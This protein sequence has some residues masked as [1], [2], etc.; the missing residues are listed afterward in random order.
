MLLGLKL[1]FF[2]TRRGPVC[3]AQAV[4]RPETATK[5]GRPRAVTIEPRVRSGGPFREEI[6]M[7]GLRA[8]T[9]S[10]AACVA[11]SALAAPA[12]AE[13]SVVTG[14]PEVAEV[15]VGTDLGTDDLYVDVFTYALFF[16]G[17]GL[18]VIGDSY[19][20]DLGVDLLDLF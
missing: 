5:R 9:V 17:V 6:S 4:F 12:S 2:F 15:G 11:F 14:V 8:L 16:G 20:V 1:K 7:K 10:L 19:G 13:V 3:I 18:E